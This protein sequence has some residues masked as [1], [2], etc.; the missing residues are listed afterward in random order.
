M[1]IFRGKPLVSSASDYKDS[2]R[3]ALRSN[4]NLSADVTIIDGVTL[5]DKDRVLLAG[6]NLASQN[7]IYSWSST[8][9]R[10]TRAIDADSSVELNAGSRV[11]VEDGNTHSKTTWILITSGNI[12]IGSTGLVFAKE[13]RLGPVDNSGTYGAANKT[14]TVT[15]DETGAINSISTIDIDVD[16][17]SY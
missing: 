3:V 2:V 13:S 8:T 14:L 7:G 6:Q 17:G 5:N 15:L 10:L 16:G 12:S 11:Y 1:P 9:S 4:L